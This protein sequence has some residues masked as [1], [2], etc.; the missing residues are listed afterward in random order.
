M[1]V[2][3]VVPTGLT[4]WSKPFIWNGFAVVLTLLIPP[5]REEDKLAALLV[6]VREVVP[7]GRPTLIFAS[8]RHHVELI[9]QLLEKE[10][11]ASTLVYGTLDQARPQQHALAACSIPSAHQASCQL[12]LPLALSTPLST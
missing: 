9:A 11:I 10:G 3:E 2:R 6:L 12:P 7:Q 8:T 4:R 1:L 5:I